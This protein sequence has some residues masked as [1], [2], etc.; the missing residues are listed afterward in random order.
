MIRA[1]LSAALLL[2]YRAVRLRRAF[3]EPTIDRPAPPLVVKT[4]DGQNFD[5]PNSG[6][7]WCW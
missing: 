5:L 7:R 3:G 1:R 4:L 2:A 6:A